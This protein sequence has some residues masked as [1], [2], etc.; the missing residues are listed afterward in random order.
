[1]FN[2]AQSK[3]D[4]PISANFNTNQLSVTNRFYYD[5]VINY[6]IS[7]EFANYHALQKKCFA[8]LYSLFPRL[9]GEA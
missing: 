5:F 2:R 4:D 1:M 6:L 8:D 7:N 3:S 9:M